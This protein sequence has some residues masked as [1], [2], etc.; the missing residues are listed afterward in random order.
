MCGWVS[1]EPVDDRVLLAGEAPGDEAAGDHGE[2]GGA[3]LIEGVLD[4]EVHQ[5]VVVGQAPALGGAHD[6]VDAGD[7]GQ[8]L[9]RADGV[10]HGEAG[11][12]AEGNLHGVLLGVVGRIGRTGAREWVRR[13]GGR[14]AGGSGRGWCRRGGRRRGAGSRRA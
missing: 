4:V 3:H 12:E 7:V 2:V 1:A 6:D 11:I 8:D 13:G 14:S 9:V 5:A 10:E